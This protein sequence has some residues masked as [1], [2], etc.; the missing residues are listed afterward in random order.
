MDSCIEIG[1]RNCVTNGD[2]I[3]VHVQTLYEKVTVTCKV[4]V[5]Y[6]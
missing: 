6:R 2:C 4:T 3:K 5:T 1:A